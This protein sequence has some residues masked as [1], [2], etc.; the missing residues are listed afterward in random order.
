M[1]VQRDTEFCIFPGK[2]LAVLFP[3]AEDDVNKDANSNDAQNI[4]QSSK[5]QQASQKIK[6]STSI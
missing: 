6:I 3:N 1:M 5:Q 4:F 2:R